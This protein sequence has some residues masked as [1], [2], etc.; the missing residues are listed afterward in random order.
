MIRNVPSDAI[1]KVDVYD[2]DEGSLN[3]DYIGS[4]ST[5]IGDGMHIETLNGIITDNRGAV[6]IRSSRYIGNYF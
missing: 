2:K 1:L 6:R 5:D 4:F 3:D